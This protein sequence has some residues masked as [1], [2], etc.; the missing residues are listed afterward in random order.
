[1]TPF[2]KIYK[3][4]SFVPKGK[5]ITYKKIAEIAN[6]KDVRVIG[7]A[8]NKNKNPK[9]IPCHRVVKSDGTFATG[10]AF[11]GKRAQ[12]QKLV[13][14]DVIFANQETVDLRNSL[15]KIPLN[16][17]VYLKVLFLR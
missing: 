10:Y 4:V 11:G 8:L 9:K 5:V 16:L 1:M 13:N 7:F 2:E 15:F 6:I 12:K 14:E 17:E 3:I